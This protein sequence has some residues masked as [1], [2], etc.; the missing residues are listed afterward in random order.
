MCNWILQPLDVSVGCGEWWVERWRSHWSWVEAAA[1]MGLVLRDE[2][3]IELCAI[4]LP[5]LFL[6]M[7]FRFSSQ[8]EE[9]EDLVSQFPQGADEAPHTSVLSVWNLPQKFGTG[10]LGQ[11]HP[12]LL[13]P[14]KHSGGR[15]P[16]CQTVAVS[17]YRTT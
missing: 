12:C 4:P 1:V 6:L 5:C 3:L 7:S 15:G 17:P 8:L 13:N 9:Q 11:P 16:R 10:D 2:P 14:E